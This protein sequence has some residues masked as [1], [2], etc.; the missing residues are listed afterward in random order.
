MGHTFWVDISS[1]AKK[2]K[3]LQDASKNGLAFIIS[4][5][6]EIAILSHEA[7]MYFMYLFYVL[8][9]LYGSRYSLVVLSFFFS[10]CGEIRV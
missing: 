7:G 3:L 5:L 9:I 8:S 10:S 1:T 2:I 4:L 6:A